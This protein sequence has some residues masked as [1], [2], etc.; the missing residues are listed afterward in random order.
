M[1]FNIPEDDEL[2]KDT[3]KALDYKMAV[4]DIE[5]LIRGAYKYATLP[6]DIATI[7]DEN[8]DIYINLSDFKDYFYSL[9]NDYDINI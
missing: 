9:L 5:V 6:V 2:V 4:L 7:S 8:G 3:M 1:E